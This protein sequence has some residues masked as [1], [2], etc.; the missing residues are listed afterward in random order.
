MNI[1]KTKNT[2]PAGFG[3]FSL[4]YYYINDKIINN[5]V[6]LI[7]PE[8]I[9]FKIKNELFSRNLSEPEMLSANKRSLIIRDFLVLDR[10][11][12]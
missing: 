10:K 12:C 4:N 9:I 6:L 11:R 3:Q 7:S 2:F 1:Y 5:Y 8:N